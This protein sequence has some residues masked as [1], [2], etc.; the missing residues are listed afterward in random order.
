M[1]E[2]D[3]DD[4][5]GVVLFVSCCG[6]VGLVLLCV[7]CFDCVGKCIVEVIGCCWCIRGFGGML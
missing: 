3:I 6:V 5:V 2:Y 1:G 4:V 7:D